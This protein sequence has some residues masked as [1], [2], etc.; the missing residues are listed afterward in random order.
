MDLRAARPICGGTGLPA[1][2]PAGT[3]L[4][5][6]TEMDGFAPADN[7]IIIGATNFPEVTWLG[8]FQQRLFIVAPSL[9]APHRVHTQAPTHLP[10]ADGWVCGPSGGATRGN[11]CRCWT[12][13][14]CG[15]AASTS[16][17]PCRAVPLTRQQH[18]PACPTLR[19]ASV[20]S[21]PHLLRVGGLCA[22]PCVRWNGT[23]P[24]MNGNLTH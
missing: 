22:F 24:A 9:R 5:L 15:P 1:A 12:R 16:R 4:Q 18:G 14:L 2:T 19:A 13:L 7:V 17:Y 20:R 8:C 21:R 11:H 6:L 23:R 10:L 3:A